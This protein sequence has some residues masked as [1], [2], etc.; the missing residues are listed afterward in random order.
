[1]SE[2]CN[3]RGKRQVVQ[4]LYECMYLPYMQVEKWRIES[5]IR[6]AKSATDKHQH[7]T[8]VL[9]PLFVCGINQSDEYQTDRFSEIPK[10]FNGCKRL[11]NCMPTPYF[12]M[13]TAVDE[14]EE[15]KAVEKSRC[16][17]S[18]LYRILC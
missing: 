4:A 6:S 7:P 14:E 15:E 17:Y 18:I 9:K 1:M 2:A 11:E 13:T 16:W 5:S 10:A 12:P 3:N 8:A